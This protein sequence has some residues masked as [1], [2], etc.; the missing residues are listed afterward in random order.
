MVACLVPPL[1]YSSE[2]SSPVIRQ[3]NKREFFIHT[4]LE[5]VVVD[6]ANWEITEKV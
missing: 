5:I 2:Y 4:F 1:H 6:G 3:I